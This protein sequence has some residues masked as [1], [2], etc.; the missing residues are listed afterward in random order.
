[1]KVLEVCAVSFTYERFVAPIA[2]ALRNDAHEVY[3]CYYDETL[4]RF[5][6]IKYFYNL[7]FPRS[8]RPIMLLKCFVCFYSFL[9]REKFD[10]VHV[11]TPLV[12]YLIRTA[13]FISS[14]PVVYHCHGY[15]FHS[16]SNIIFYWIGFI[17]EFL[18]FLFTKSTFYVSEED[19]QLSQK[20]PLSK[21][22]SF[23]VGNGVD[24]SLFSSTNALSDHQIRSFFD[25]YNINP[26]FFDKDSLIILAVGRLVSEKGFLDLLNAFS[27]ALSSGL[28]SVSL[29]LVIVGEP[30][31]SDRDQTL[32]QILDYYKTRYPNNFLSIP[33]VSNSDLPY[34]YGIS[35]IFVNPSHRE[36]L[37]TTTLESLFSGTYTIAS[38]VRGNRE[39]LHAAYPSSCQSIPPKDSS[40]LSKLLITLANPESVQ[41]LKLN[42][43][44]FSSINNRLLQFWTLSSVL[45][46]IVLCLKS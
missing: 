33:F 23:L 41:F 14:T 31:K 35:T 30:L 21:N 20:F 44:R 32:I 12:S 4:P 25:S 24:S 28:L 40:A 6:Q 1:M 10:L 8:F 15:P 29:K 9:S 37:S 2:Q 26:A 11:H 43:N 38:D 45:E 7:P 27:N 18:F 39:T 16:G 19:Y 34:L 17:T 13:C 42:Q 46:R 5:C 36:G 22:K 3:T